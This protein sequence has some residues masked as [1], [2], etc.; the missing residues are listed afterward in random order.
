VKKENSKRIGL[1]QRNGERD[2]ETT[3]HRE[4]IYERQNRAQS[5]RNNNEKKTGDS[6]GP[7]KNKMDE[8]FVIIW[9]II[10]F[11]C[12]GEL[13]TAFRELH[14]MLDWTGVPWALRD[15]KIFWTNGWRMH[16]LSRIP[17]KM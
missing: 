14:E 1:R 16:F 13:N 5:Q 10:T 4:C 3:T 12:L 9:Q 6:I 8:T 2:R 17:R 15:E 11:R 7:T